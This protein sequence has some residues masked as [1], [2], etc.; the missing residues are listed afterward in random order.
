MTYNDIPN[1]TLRHFWER[2][3]IYKEEKFNFE[4]HK[5]EIKN[6]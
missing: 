4:T 3:N 1:Y 2:L 6:E 5:I